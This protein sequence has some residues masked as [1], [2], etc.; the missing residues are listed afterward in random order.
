MMKFHGYWFSFDIRHSRFV[1][2]RFALQILRTL[3]KTRGLGLFARLL[4]VDLIHGRFNSLR[5]EKLAGMNCLLKRRLHGRSVLSV[6][7]AKDKLMDRL[8][9][10]WAANPDLDPAELSS[11][12][13]IKKGLNPLVPS[14]AAP[15]GNL[16]SSER[17][18]QV[19]MENQNFFGPDAQRCRALFDGFSAQVHESLRTK[20]K[21]FTILVSSGAALPF[22]ASAQQPDSQRPGPTVDH[23]EPDVVTR[24]AVSWPGVPKAYQKE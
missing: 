22:K 2:L 11:P 1:I 23:H 5:D 13:M 24:V 7:G 16:H 14:I 4:P 3:P 17:E 8:P 6:K 12:Q 10:P 18:V 9:L 15:L 20:Q 21:N 19:I